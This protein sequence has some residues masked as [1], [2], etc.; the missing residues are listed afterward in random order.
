MSLLTRPQ[1]QVKR[2]IAAD[3][4]ELLRELRA[5]RL[6]LGR[7]LAAQ[8]G[9][10]AHGES[11]EDVEFRVFSQFGDDGIIQYLVRRMAIRPQTFVEFGVA[12]YTES[13]TRFLLLNNNWSGLV[14]DSDAENVAHIRADEEFWKHDLQTACAFIDRNN[15]N[16]LLIDHGFHGELGLLHIDLDGNDY[17]VWE[18]LEAVTAQ[19][20][21]LE[22]NSV[23]GA[24]RPVTVPYDAQFVRSR[25][26]ASHLYWGAA[27]PALCHLAQRKGYV[28]VGSNSAGNNA[29]FVRAGC[30]HGLRPLTAAEGYVAS[31]FRESRDAHGRLTYARGAA[32]LELIHGMP[33]INV[34]TG[35]QENL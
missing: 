16:A 12:D 21:I 6:L 14:L 5:Q 7:L 8:L 9:E 11:F 1:R 4:P 20:V 30:E 24:E 31:K 17:W 2:S 18:A 10:R 28:F 35:A 23:F 19:L 34:V 29:Y 27:L 26:H 32:R 3:A 33:V 15:V 13:N 22:Y 25:A